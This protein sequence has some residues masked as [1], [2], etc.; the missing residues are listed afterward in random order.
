MASVR[1][2]EDPTEVE[3]DRMDV[4]D[5]DSNS[6]GSRHNQDDGSEDAEMRFVLIAERYLMGH[7]IRGIVHLEAERFG[8]VAWNDNKVYSV[9]REKPDAVI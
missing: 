9:D 4:Q 1:D 7:D 6:R 2:S 3:E 8:V 5:R